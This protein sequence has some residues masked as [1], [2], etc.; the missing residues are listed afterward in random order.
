MEIRHLALSFQRPFSLDHRIVLMMISRLF[1]FSLAFCLSSTGRENERKQRSNLQIYRRFASVLRIAVDSWRRGGT[2]STVCSRIS[3]RDPARDG[4][5]NIS[6]VEIALFDRL[7]IIRGSRWDWS[8]LIF[9]TIRVACNH[10][11]VPETLVNPTCSVDREWPWIKLCYRFNSLQGKIVRNTRRPIR[12]KLS[13]SGFRSDFDS[14]YE[15]FYI[16]ICI[17]RTESFDFTSILR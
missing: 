5:V 12:E 15:N 6:F 13:E 2:L 10:P 8:G 4:P 11:R 1:F 14:I 9:T 17:Y 3:F 7:W 16:H